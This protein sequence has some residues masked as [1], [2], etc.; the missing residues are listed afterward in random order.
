MSIASTQHATKATAAALVKRRWYEGVRKS[1]YGLERIT[2]WAE[3]LV[4]MVA[5]VLVG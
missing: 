1:L 3:E 2:C 5:V 4:A